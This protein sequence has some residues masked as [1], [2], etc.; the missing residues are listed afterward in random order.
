[1]YP[2]DY[3]LHDYK[4]GLCRSLLP[5]YWQQQVFRD[6]GLEVGRPGGDLQGRFALCPGY[7]LTYIYIYMYMYLHICMCTDKYV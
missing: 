1:M 5:I 7:V 6:V 3:R 4:V 2:H